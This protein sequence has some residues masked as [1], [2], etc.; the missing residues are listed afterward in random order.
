MVAA[1]GGDPADLAAPDATLD[2]ALRAEEVDRKMDLAAA[3]AISCGGSAAHG[4]A[5]VFSERGFLEQQTST[6]HKT[7]PRES[8]W[9]VG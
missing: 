7:L 1:R 3:E 6:V 5:D 9:M 2:A 4:G 8:V